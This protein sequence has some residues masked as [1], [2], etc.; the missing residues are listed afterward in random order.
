MNKVTE[1]SALLTTPVLHPQPRSALWVSPE[2]EVQELDFMQVPD[3]VSRH[4]PMICHRRWVEAKIHQDL[5]NFLDVLELFAFVRPAR[6]CLPTPAGLAEQLGLAKPSSAADAAITIAKS[7][8]A[9]FDIIAAAPEHDQRQMRDIAEMMGKGGWGWASLILDH[10][11]VTSVSAGPPD[12][13]QAAVC[14]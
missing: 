6:F 7:A 1:F 2:G 10:L 8:L 4:I 9:L 13:R 12:G 3:L 14:R 5:P 11:G